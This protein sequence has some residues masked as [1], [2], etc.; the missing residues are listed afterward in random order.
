MKNKNRSKCFFSVSARQTAR[1]P[2]RG[3]SDSRIH[4]DSSLRVSTDAPGTNLEALRRDLRRSNAS[5]ADAGRNCQRR[6]RGLS[7]P[8]QVL[9]TTPRTA[10]TRPRAPNIPHPPRSTGR[11]AFTLL[12]KTRQE[13]SGPWQAR[14][15]GLM[16]DKHVRPMRAED[17]QPPNDRYQ[18]TSQAQGGS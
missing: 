6:P 14:Q 8:I 1:M 5:E 3:P 12:L 4:F 18:G 16:R 9:K 13:S 15:L 10:E 2:L 7:R 11:L 17:L